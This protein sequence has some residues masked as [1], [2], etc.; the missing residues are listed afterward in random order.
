MV[1]SVVCAHAVPWT[2]QRGQSYRQQ[3]LP[4]RHL[5]FS[6]VTK[7]GAIKF[8]QNRPNGS[9]TFNLAPVAAIT[10]SRVV[11]SAISCSTRPSGVTSITAISVTMRFTTFMPVSGSVH[12]FR[13]L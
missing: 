2:Q 8:N 12:F 4:H 6:N 13:I 7:V 1:E 3:R 10:A 5:T 11:S 9:A